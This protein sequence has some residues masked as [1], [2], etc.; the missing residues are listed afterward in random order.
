ML[1]QF[2]DPIYASRVTLAFVCFPAL[3]VKPRGLFTFYATATLL[4]LLMIASFSSVIS[5]PRAA[6]VN[7]ATARAA[8]GLFS[9]VFGWLLWRFC[10]GERSREY[11][12]FASL[13]NK[14]PENAA[15]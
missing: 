15:Q 6:G 8:A 11:F 9:L 7:P 5:D 12:G 3:I 4:A 1:A 10:F 2:K 13:S 14:P